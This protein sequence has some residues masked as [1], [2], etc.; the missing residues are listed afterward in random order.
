MDRD[1]AI[2]NRVLIGKK[3]YIFTKWK[4]FVKYEKENGDG[5]T[6]VRIG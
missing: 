5:K 4:T 1:C 2:I 6:A 3:E